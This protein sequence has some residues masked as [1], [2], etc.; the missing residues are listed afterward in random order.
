MTRGVIYTTSIGARDTALPHVAQQTVNADYVCFA[1]PAGL[2]K[3][4]NTGIWTMRPAHV[5]DD[6]AIRA[7]RFHKCCPH[8][9]LPGYDWWIW[10][11]GNATL[12]GD[13]S[14]LLTEDLVLLSH[15]RKRTL[16]A[17]FDACAAV[18]NCGPGLLYRQ[19]AAYE[20]A[21]VP[22]HALVPQTSV[23][24]R[25]NIGWVIAFNATWWQELT[26]HTPRLRTPNASSR[27]GSAAGNRQ[28]R[29]GLVPARVQR[30]NA[31]RISIYC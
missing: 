15:P 31:A 21:G 10:V 14:E 26:Q 3:Y 28:R 6:C 29:F 2:A 5:V 9:V 11:D 19:R 23:M 25:K 17:E 1:D 24:A 30:P 4:N 13:M 27:R 22:M 7:A 12:R 16:Q 20:A 18:W 8:V